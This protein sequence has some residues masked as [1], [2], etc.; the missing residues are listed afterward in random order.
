MITAISD[1]EEVR[2]AALDALRAADDPQAPD[3]YARML[4]VLHDL[5][6]RPLHA[7]VAPGYL[8]W[9]EWPDCLRSYNIVD[10]PKP[11]RDGVGWIAV[12]T[13]TRVLL[14]PDH[15]DAG[16]RPQALEWAPGDTTVATSC[17]CG[18]R[19]EGLTPA[20]T[21]RCTEWWRTHVRRAVTHG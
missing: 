3:R 15:A 2:R 1:P 5:H 12:R 4:A 10:G 20:S 16:H 6:W 7:D 21:G 8:R 18:E 9:C 19:G 14:C 17:E 13:G 11:E